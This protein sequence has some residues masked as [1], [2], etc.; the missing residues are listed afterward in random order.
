MPL[1]SSPTGQDLGHG[2]LRGAGRCWMRRIAWSAAA[3]FTLAAGAVAAG[4]WWVVW[5]GPTDERAG[6]DTAGIQSPSEIVCPLFLLKKKMSFRE[7][8]QF[9][10]IRLVLL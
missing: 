1:F 9:E 8:G 3:A 4:F 5:A 10:I 2:A 6:E 7:S